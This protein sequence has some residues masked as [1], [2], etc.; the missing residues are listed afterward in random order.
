[1]NDLILHFLGT[2]GEIEEENKNHKMNSSLLLRY[3]DLRILIDFGHTWKGKWDEIKATHL[4]LTHAHLDH[5]T[6]LPEKIAIPVFVNEHIRDELKTYAKKDIEFEDLRIR[7]NFEIDDLVFNCYEVEHSPKVHTRVIKISQNDFNILY[8][9][10][11]L[12]LKKEYLKDIELYIGDGASV[13]KDLKIHASIQHQCSWLEAMNVPQA[14]WT[15]FGKE[16]LELEDKG[17]LLETIK[18]YAPEIKHMIAMDGSKFPISLFKVEKWTKACMEELESDTDRD[19]IGKGNDKDK[20]II[21]KFKNLPS[22]VW[23]PNFINLAGSVL[24]PKAE[25]RGGAND[26]DI[27]VRAEREENGDYIIRLDKSLRLKIDRILK[28]NLGHR[29]IDWLDST[30]GP[31]WR[32]LPLFDLVLKPVSK[33]EIQEI[34]EPEFAEIFYKGIRPAFGSPGGKRYLAKEICSII[35]EHKI[36][37]EPFIGGGAVFFRKKRSGKEVIN[38]LDADIAFCYRFMKRVTDDEIKELKKFDWVRSKEQFERLKNIEPQN[39]VERFYKIIYLRTTSY[40]NIGRSPTGEQRMG[41]TIHLLDRLPKIRERLKDVTILQW[42]FRKILEKYDLAETFFYLDPPYIN[43]WMG[44]SPTISPSEIYDAIKNLKGKWLLSYSNIAEIKK[45]FHKFHISI[46][47]VPRPLGGWGASKDHI[48]TE[49]LIS[50][51]S[52]KKQWLYLD[53][54]KDILG[55]DEYDELEKLALPYEPKKYTDAQLADD[56]RILAGWYSTLKERGTFK[57]T[58]EE[59]INDFGVPLLKEILDRDKITFRPEN[60]TD[61]ARE[62]YLKIFA[63]AIQDAIYLVEPHGQLIYDGKKTLVVKTKDFGPML[64]MRALVSG[65]NCYG[66]IRFEEPKKIN[67]EEFRALQDRHRITEK[68]RNNWWPN[69]TEFY[70]YEIRDFIPLPKP[71]DISERIPKDAQVFFAL[72]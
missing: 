62:L 8:A 43:G 11:V 67:L 65:K 69:V 5:V 18:S 39:D 20:E 9:P 33:L 47:K 38:D 64:E 4:I 15:H 22:F 66:Y 36:Y 13:S 70:V 28:E 42:D 2:K 68:E 63:Q 6:G 23:I 54:S 71:L 27:V 52:P 16:A 49:V 72:R 48:G 32:Y 50:N 40:G 44:N 29:S 26:I 3:K 57:Y 55:K 1:M 37:V 19:T 7:N 31:N 60:W 12:Y 58:E 35:P 17:K 34:D 24:Y 46:T 56:W 25:E 30:Y 41:L 45:L 10:D 51:F 21:D 14:I 53:K 59:I 61:T